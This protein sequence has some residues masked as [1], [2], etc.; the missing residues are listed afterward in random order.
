MAGVKTGDGGFGGIGKFDVAGGGQG[1]E[2]DVDEAFV[3]RQATRFHEDGEEDA[4]LGT[5]D[6]LFTG[7]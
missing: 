6:D 2:G 7:D 1:F 3:T 5:G 4:V